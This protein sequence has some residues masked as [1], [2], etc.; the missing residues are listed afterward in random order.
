MKRFWSVI[1]F[2]NYFVLSLGAW[3]LPCDFDFN[4][5]ED[6]EICAPETI[7]LVIPFGAPLLDVQWE[8][9]ELFLNP[10][11]L[12]TSAAISETT[13]L[14]ATISV[15]SSLNLVTNGDF[16]QG[17]QD[18]SSDYI[19]GTGGGV[20][21]LSNEGQ[22]A[23]ASNASDTHNHFDNCPDHNGGGN[24][25][26]V[27]ASGLPNSVWCQTITVTPDTE[28]E[29]GAW[30]TSVTAENPAQL[31]FSINGV[32][33]G[34]GLTASANT[35]FWQ[36]FAANWV[37]GTVTSAEICIN[38]VNLTP[39]G[40]DFAIDDIT[41]R[42]ICVLED[43]LEVRVADA[44]ATW[45]SIADLCESEA[46]VTF[47]Q[48]LDSDA[49][50]GGEW[51]LDGNVVAGD[52][53]T[54]LSAGTHELTYSVMDGMCSDELTQSVEINMDHTTG[55]PLE[56]LIICEGSAG[57][58]NLFD[59]LNDEDNGG[60]WSQTGGI[61]I[62][63]GVLN[64]ITGDVNISNEAAGIYQFSYDFG[65]SVPCATAPSVITIEITPLPV[66]DAGSDLEITCMTDFVQLGG[67]GTT[68]GFDF[69]YR[70]VNLA[71]QEVISNEAIAEVATPGTYELEVENTS[72]GCISKDQVTVISSAHQLELEAHGDAVGCA[73]DQNGQIVIDAING[74]VEPYLYAINGGD[75]VASPSLTGLSDGDYS[76]AVMDVEGCTVEANI[77]ILYPN[78]LIAVI[79]NSNGGEDPR[80]RLGEE[81]HLTV[82]TSVSEDLIE[83]VIW[84]PNISDCGGCTSVTVQPTTFPNTLYSVTVFDVNGCTATASLTVFLEE[85]EDIFV[86]NAFSPND[87]GVNDIFYVHAGPSVEEIESIQ[88]ANRWGG[89][90]YSRQ[91]ILPNDVEQ[92][93]N[94]T[95]SGKRKESAVYVYSIRLRLINGKSVIQSGEVVLLR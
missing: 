35:C 21:L 72:T 4:V 80:V 54:P 83:S 67:T 79:D 49:T 37:S 70:W 25:M 92:G 29:F 33:L 5:G 88:I 90:V 89:I 56:P 18:F 32:P 87:D 39:N 57:V 11:A 73:E 13:T 14:R 40:N 60:S 26:V 62:S 42:T 31:E 53:P 27:N 65:L 36:E 47:D 74:G 7:Q 46:M 86:P 69:T 44:D 81:L 28:Y 9:A 24:M 15:L 17:D 77:N 10:N 20:G 8:P 66:A 63:S 48:W 43:E 38:N 45:Y 78:E 61:P 95:E 1:V 34:N 91:H 55:T 30:L 58:V 3:Q 94:G 93:W 2:L 64:S 84:S 19:Y 71:T 50:T 82:Q 41:F 68:T 76:L 12:S 51:T 75:F 85:A 59:R 16:E 22:Y 23:I 6:I 52:M